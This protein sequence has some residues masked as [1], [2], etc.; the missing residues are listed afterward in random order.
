MRQMVICSTVIGKAKKDSYVTSSGARPGDSILITKAV[1]L[2]GT[3][4]LAHD[5]ADRLMSLL[6]GGVVERASSS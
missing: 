3:A 6:P 5:R 4:I 2:E 1:G